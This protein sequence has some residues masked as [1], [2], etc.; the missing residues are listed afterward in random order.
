MDDVKAG[1]L[2]PLTQGGCW[3]P[4]WAHNPDHAGS[5]PVPATMSTS[6][7][8]GWREIQA[9]P[10]A[11]KHARRLLHGVSTYNKQAAQ[12][13]K[14]LAEFITLRCAP[15][16]LG[17]RLFPNGKEISESFAAF[18]A[19]RY[20]LQEFP[21]GDPGIT[22]VAVG[23]GQTP[24]TAATFAMRSAWNCYSVDPDIKGGTR[25]WAS[26]QRLTI[27]PKRIQDVTIEGDRVVVVAVHSHA[28]L[29]LA[30]PSIRARSA[31]AVI[32]IP[33]CVPMTLDCREPSL[34]YEDKGI[35]S[36]RRTVRIWK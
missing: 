14:Y 32:A 30:L 2:D 27:V 19:A 11:S 18:E 17:L 5:I 31:L 21:L 16:M 33:C 35:I 26:I 10:R 7:A 15:D 29:E 6:T 1:A 8:D 28:R 20:R 3:L 36:P 24:R 4:S 23:D 34:E 12:M 22:L 25:R 13:V 9:S